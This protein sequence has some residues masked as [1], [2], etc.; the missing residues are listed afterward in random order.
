MSERVQ[1]S[2]VSWKPEL[3]QKRPQ[4]ELHNVSTLPGLASAVREQQTLRVFLPMAI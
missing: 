4:T 1:A 2:V 3:L